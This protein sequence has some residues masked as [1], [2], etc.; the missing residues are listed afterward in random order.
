MAKAKKGVGRR[1]KNLTLGAKKP[2]PFR[3]AVRKLLET[4]PEPTKRGR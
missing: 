1:K 4:P 2:I 3:D